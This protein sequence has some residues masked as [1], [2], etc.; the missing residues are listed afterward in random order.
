MSLR[1]RLALASEQRVIIK[2]SLGHIY[3]T[4]S[5]PVGLSASRTF[6]RAKYTIPAA[7]SLLHSLRCVIL[8]F[9]ITRS[10][11]LKDSVVIAR[12]QSAFISRS[13]WLEFALA[14]SLNS[15]E[16][17]TPLAKYALNMCKGRTNLRFH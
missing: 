6:L 14:C 2:S 3:C 15:L 8:L 13:F 7:I 16:N 5:L 11:M 10:E 1:M 9:E 17:M 12:L 4:R